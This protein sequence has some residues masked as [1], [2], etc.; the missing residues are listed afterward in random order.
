LARIEGG[1]DGFQSVFNGKDLSGWIGAVGNYDVVDGAIH[2]KPG[3]GGNLLTKDEYNDFVARLEFKLPPG[4]N[5]GLAIRAASPEGDMA[6]DASEIQVLD[7]SSAQYKDLKPFQFHGSLYGL[8]PATRGYLRPVGEWN[9]E[10]VTVKGDHVTVRLNGYE[11]LD[12]DLAKVREKPA[13]GREHPGASRTS[14]H[15]GFCGHNEPVAFRN[16]R[17]KR[18]DSN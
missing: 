18:L 16:I 10:E 14:G 3:H 5:N 2:C 11:I 1:E 12:A 6:Y 13:D 4:G 17:I 7:D 15:F 9:S 8:A